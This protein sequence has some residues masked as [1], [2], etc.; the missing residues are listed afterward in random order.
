LKTRCPRCGL[1]Q[2][3]EE[4]HDYATSRLDAKTVICSSCGTEEAL[5][6]AGYCSQRRWADRTAFI[7]A[8]QRREA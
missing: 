8:Y 4:L 2:V 6:D 3:D 5:A 7:Q 1:A